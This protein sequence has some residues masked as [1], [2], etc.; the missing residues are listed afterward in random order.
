MSE[1]KAL[2]LELAKMKVAEADFWEAVHGDIGRKF[3]EIDPEG[4]E[5]ASKEYSA[6]CRLVEAAEF[7]LASHPDSDVLTLSYS[8]CDSVKDHYDIEDEI[9]KAN[10]PGVMVDCEYSCFYAYV[11]PSVREEFEARLTAKFPTLD[12]GVTD[13]MVGDSEYRCLTV[14]GLGN[15]TRAKEYVKENS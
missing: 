9:R 7:N 13:N 1:Y 2:K 6:Y 15:W 8:G 5:A 3:E 11:H 4:H 10:M 14:P 12:W